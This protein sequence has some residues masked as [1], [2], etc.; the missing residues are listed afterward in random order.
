MSA[1][2]GEHPFKEGS[3]VRVRVPEGKNIILEGGISLCGGDTTLGLVR[4]ATFIDA[5]KEGRPSRRLVY[6]VHAFGTESSL[7]PGGD[8]LQK[9]LLRALLLSTDQQL[10]QVPKSW[11]EEAEVSNLTQR[12]EA[13][14]ARRAGMDTF[15]AHLRPSIAEGQALLQ[16]LRAPGSGSKDLTPPNHGA[17]GTKAFRDGRERSAGGE[18]GRFEKD[19]DDEEDDVET[20]LLG[21]ASPLKRV[22][23]TPSAARRSEKECDEFGAAKS[24]GVRDTHLAALNP[25][26]LAPRGALDVLHKYVPAALLPDL[27]TAL[28]LEEDAPMSVRAVKTRYG[29]VA[30]ASQIMSRPSKFPLTFTDQYKH[31]HV[32]IFWGQTSHFLTS[33]RGRLRF[34]GWYTGGVIS[35]QPPAARAGPMRALPL[36]TPRAVSSRLKVHQGGNSLGTHR[37]RT[38]A[39]GE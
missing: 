25:L 22:R 29:G 36:G 32:V 5:M 26:H 24:G 2:A 19:D 21:L 33:L 1:G 13:A 10:E 15:V 3:V 34:S 4:A 8:E 37:R 30:W 12:F 16:R 27:L 9:E 39:P 7:T 28:S 11:V 38:R 20:E 18:R 17:G 14:L 23:A 6:D 31:P 35:W